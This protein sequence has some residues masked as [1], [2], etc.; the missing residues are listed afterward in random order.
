L[1]RL[2]GGQRLHVLVVVAPRRIRPPARVA[3]LRPLLCRRELWQRDVA[4]A[5]S[6]VT[7][8]LWLSG[9][10]GADYLEN[11]IALGSEESLHRIS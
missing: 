11:G 1:R 6:A 8:A 5:V 4:G 7:W 3:Q 10:H 9:Y 2:R